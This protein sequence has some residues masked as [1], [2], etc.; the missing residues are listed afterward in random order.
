MSHVINLL[1]C[2]N[3]FHPPRHHFQ[4][5]LSFHIIRKIACFSFVIICRGT[6]QG[7]LVRDFDYR[8]QEMMDIVAPWVRSG[9]IKFEETIMHGFDVLPSALASLFEGK[10]IGKL[11]VKAKD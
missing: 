6:I 11:I 8:K 4:P 3:P 2:Q 5:P 9:K 7:I 10:N 1:L